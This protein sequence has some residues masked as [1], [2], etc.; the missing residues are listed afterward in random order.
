MK[1]RAIETIRREMV[2]ERGF[3]LRQWNYETSQ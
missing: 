3:K 2:E 1:D